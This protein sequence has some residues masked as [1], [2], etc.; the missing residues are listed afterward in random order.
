MKIKG[1]TILGVISFLVVFWINFIDFKL[2]TFSLFIGKS[3]NVENIIENLCLA[4]LTAYF[5][6]FINIYLVEM[7]EKKKV[8]PFLSFKVKSI[9]SANERFF[10]I[11]FQDKNVKVSE[12]TSKKL[13]EVLDEK[14]L[15]SLKIY[16]H[17]NSTLSEFISKNREIIFTN[18]SKVLESGKYVDDELRILLLEMRESLFLKE[19][20]AFNLKDIELDSLKKYN[21]VLYRYINQHRKLEKYFD[22][23]FRNYYLLNF[24]RYFRKK[25]K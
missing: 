15:K 24:P 20:Y 17:E 5:F 11:L 22:K 7:R 19:N 9:L 1:L 6:Y 12:L 2:S 25:V 23:N 8:L 16:Y 21:N 4:Y 14:N 13:E 18:I 3:K 10:S